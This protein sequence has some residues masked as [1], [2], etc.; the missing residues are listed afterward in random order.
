L[1]NLMTSKQKLPKEQLI[2]HPP[3]PHRF[4]T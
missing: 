4:S 3:N 1:D 2:K